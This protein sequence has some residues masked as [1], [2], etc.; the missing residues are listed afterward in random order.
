MENKKRKSVPHVREGFHDVTPFLIV[1]GAVALLEF[2]K[3]A[4]GAKVPFITKTDE[5]RVIH[6]YLQIGDSI[7]MV[8]DTMEGMK[9]ETALLYLYVDD[10]DATYKK[11]LAAGAK[12][13]AE[14][15]DQ[16]YGDRAGG[17][18]DPWGNSWWVGTQIEELS[19]E[20][21]DQRSRESVNVK[22]EA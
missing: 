7:I 5:G 11:A 1:D 6:A 20:E 4:F 21:L 2:A 18:R 15:K 9:A 13:V 14:P 16:F 8:A 3:K 19:N 22:T 10:C 17:V 12:V